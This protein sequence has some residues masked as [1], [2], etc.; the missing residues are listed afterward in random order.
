M[1]I[2]F[3][4]VLLL[5]SLSAEAEEAR[6]WNGFTFTP[7]VGLRHLGLDVTRRSDGYTANIAQDLDA[8]VFFSLN[9]E[10]PR[11]RF[12]NS[13]WGVSIVNYNSFVTLDHQWYNYNS[14]STGV[15]SGERVDVDSEVSGRYSYVVP[16]IFYESGKP[17]ESS[18]KF[19]LGYGWWNSDLSGTVRLTPN[20][21]PTLL[22]PATPVD[23]ST[24]TMGYLMTLSWRTK[25]DWIWEMSL[26]GITFDDAEYD[27][28]IEEVA[29]TFGK[30]IRL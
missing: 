15:G 21:R 12:P 9:I 18:F 25:N 19:A 29:L 20:N 5:V 14:G 11:F 26:G 23:L 4:I 22:T 16:Q 13:N 30:T 7:G 3:L 27:Y 1:R 24:T 6:L 10:S 17:G 28:E 8:K 2:G